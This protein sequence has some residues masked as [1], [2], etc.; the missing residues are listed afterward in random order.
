MNAHTAI[1][2]EPRSIEGEQSLL[3]AV[4]MN[5]AAFDV[6]E[7]RVDAADFY[8]PIHAAIGARSRQPAR[9]GARLISG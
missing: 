9:K 7:G 5:P 6:V 8:E 3:G 4:L 1:N 2:M